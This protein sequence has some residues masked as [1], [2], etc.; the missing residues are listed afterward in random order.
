VQIGANDPLSPKADTVPASQACY[1]YEY[2][3]ADS[4]GTS[5]TYLSGDIEIDTNAPTAPALAYSAL[6]NAYWSGSTLFYRSNATSG[7]FTITATTTDAE[8]GIAI[9]RSRP[10]LRAGPLPQVRS[11]SEPIAGALPTQRRRRAPRTPPR[12]TTPA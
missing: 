10:S 7:A 8:S 11:A 12:P 5:T 4:L 1:R 2:V 3:V 6:T 9:T